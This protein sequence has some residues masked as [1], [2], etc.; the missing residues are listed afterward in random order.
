MASRKFSSPIARA[1]VNLSVYKAMVQT[2]LGAKSNPWIA[3]MKECRINYNCAKAS[4]PI[5]NNEP[6]L[7]INTKKSKENTNVNEIKKGPKSRKR[8][9]V[10]WLLLSCALGA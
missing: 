7:P 3:Y 5:E 10:S 1:F 8:F 9:D 6:P 4:A 2:P